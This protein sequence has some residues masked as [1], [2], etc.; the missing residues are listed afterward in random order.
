MGFDDSFGMAFAKAQT[1]AG[2]HLPKD[3]RVIITGERPGQGHGDAHRPA[4]ARH[5]LPHRRHRGHARY[6][7]SRGVPCERVFKV[8]EARPN[9]VDHII[10]GDVALLINTPL[11][12]QSQYDDYATRRAAI[13]YGFRTSPRCPRECGRGRDQRAAEQDAGGEVDSGADGGAVG[14]NGERGTGNGR[15]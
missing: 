11:G 5:G 15:R 3:G 6:L 12:K 2:T 1:S 14:G 7:R 8:N 13:Q 4:A 9:M 10:S